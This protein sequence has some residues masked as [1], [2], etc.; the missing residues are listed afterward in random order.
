MQHDWVAPVCGHCGGELKFDYGYK[1]YCSHKCARA[2]QHTGAEA[3]ATRRKNR[4]SSDEAVT[5][6]KNKLAAYDTIYMPLLVEGGRLSKHFTAAKTANN[7]EHSGIRYADIRYWLSHRIPWSNGWSETVYCVY[8]GVV[9]CP[10]CNICT[11]P[12]TYISF[13]KGYRKYCS[14]KCCTNDKD[15]QNRISAAN[16]KNAS[17]RGKKISAAKQ[18]R[19]EEE[20]RIEVQKVCMTKRINGTYSTSQPEEEL[21]AYILQKFPDMKRQYR[22]PKY[23]FACDFYI[24]CIDTYIELQGTWTHGGHPYSGSPEDIAVVESWRAKETP[25]YDS[26]VNI[27]TVSD[28]N[29]RKTAEKNGLRYYELFPV[30]GKHS[31]EQYKQ[32][33]DNLYEKYKQEHPGNC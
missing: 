9:E 25:Y 16:T 17:T 18:A 14:Q 12:V 32:L 5:I 4:L 33:I 10:H 29:K 23:P 1:E 31:I 6:D 11:K 13:E 21:A 26:A 7:A 28:V 3:S 27:W 22:S 8:N 20:I 2:H 24:P 19:T 15:I 30:D